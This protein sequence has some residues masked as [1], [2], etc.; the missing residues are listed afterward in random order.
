MTPERDIC[1]SEAFS[2]VAGKH[3]SLCPVKHCRKA[4]GPKKLL[5]HAHHQ[6]LLRLRYPVKQA[7]RG[8][9]ARAKRRGLAC[10][11]TL[12]DFRHICEATGYAKERRTNGNSLTLDRIDRRHGYELWNVRVITLS[13]NSLK[14]LT[15]KWVVRNGI[16]IPWERIDIDA[17][18]AIEAQR[19]AMRES[20]V[21][22]KINRWS[23][24]IDEDEEVDSAIFDIP[25]F[26]ATINPNN[27]F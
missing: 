11:I 21:A 4:K 7:W 23:A 25:D 2:L 6:A 15:E 20:K 8:L 10:T 13:E 9:L 24:D 19:Q 3:S 5:C 16:E 27:P 26:I 18:Q 17:W 12:D 22:E 1:A 14:G